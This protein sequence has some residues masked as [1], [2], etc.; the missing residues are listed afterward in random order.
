MNIPRKPMETRTL[1]QPAPSRAERL[2]RGS[3]DQA[4]CL[5]GL[6]FAEG[7]AAF[8]AR[9]HADFIGFGTHG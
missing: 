3:E 6:E 9:C 7:H 8:T 2:R 4:A 5:T 1:N